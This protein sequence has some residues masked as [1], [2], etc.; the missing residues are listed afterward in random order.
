MVLR[1]KNKP[2]FTDPARTFRLTLT[3]DERLYNGLQS[4]AKKLGLTR[5]EY[6]RVLLDAAHAARFG[7]TGDTQLEDIVGA[8][9]LLYGSGFETATIARV[10]KITEPQVV[11]IIQ[12]WKSHNRGAA[13]AA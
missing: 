3:V 5:S 13:K 4:A 2:E 9:L 6:A 11:G 12:Q 7:G 10:L 1:R 8:T